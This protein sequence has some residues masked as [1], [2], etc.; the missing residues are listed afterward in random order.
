MLGAILEDALAATGAAFG[1]IQLLEPA[2]AH[3]AIQ[4]ERGFRTRFLQ[5]FDRVDSG[6]AACGIALQEGERVI[7]DD[8][9]DSTIFLRTA[10]L[11][12]L[13]DAGARAVQSTPLRTSS[14][15]VL[16][17][18]STHYATPHQPRPC[19]LL[20]IDQLAQEAVATLRWHQGCCLQ[21][22]GPLRLDGRNDV[23]LTHDKG[24]YHTL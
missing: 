15:E 16:G 24:R 12:V 22:T 1:N 5:F 17:V 2:S 20:V 3:L 4:V 6:Q 19:D 9:T 10:A 8:V 23:I 7:V 21:Q 13:L 18:L 11:E 14:G